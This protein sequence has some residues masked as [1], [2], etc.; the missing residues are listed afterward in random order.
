MVKVF[1]VANQ[2]GGV[3]KSTTVVNLAACLGQKGRKVLCIDID[4]QGNTTSGFGI[5]KKSVSLSAYNVLA[6]N[7]DMLSAV[8]KTDFENV[9]LLP[10]DSSMAGAEIQLIQSPDRLNILRSKII[11][12]KQDYDYILIDCPPSLST[13][14]LNALVACDELIVPLQCEFYSLE[15]LAQLQSTVN[16]VRN[17]N[18]SVK[19]GGI[20]FTMFDPRLNLTMQV[21]N[22]I[23]RFYPKQ[24]FN[25][26]IPRNVR[27]SEAPSFGM[28]VIYYDKSSKG[29]KAY[30]DLASEIMGDV[31]I[32]SVKKQSPVRKL[33]KLGKG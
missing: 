19:I 30:Y 23:K 5:S 33:F 16:L 20:L 29:A 6:E 31:Q 32:N 2:K 11:P 22:E 24:V 21:V 26:V 18:P 27:L 8:I 28:P 15:G 10:S 13:V 17:Y 1:A 4:A 14:T 9:W 7:A 25:T 12:C 3:G